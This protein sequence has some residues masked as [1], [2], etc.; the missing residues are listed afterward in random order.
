[1]A[2]VRCCTMKNVDVS[3][4]IAVRAAMPNAINA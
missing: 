2:A 3:S 1:M 4:V